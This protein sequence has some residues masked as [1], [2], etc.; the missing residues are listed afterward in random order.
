MKNVLFEY[1]FI[2]AALIGFLFFALF[3]W[4]KTKGIIS[5]LMLTAKSMAKDTI[6]KS[7]AAQEQ[8]VLERAYMYLPKWITM[9]IP[10]EVMLKLIRYLYHMAK[11]Y[12]DDGKLNN[13]I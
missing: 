9:F 13:S 2:I 3:E 10:K 5:K 8:W 4:E 1:R 7:G 6:L 12:L 11:D